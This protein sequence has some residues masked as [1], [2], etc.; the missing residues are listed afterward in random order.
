MSA[1]RTGVV[2]ADGGSRSTT[3]SIG[4]SAC[5]LARSVSSSPVSFTVRT[6]DPKRR[7]RSAST[8]S[9]PARRDDAG[10]ERD[11]DRDG[12]AAEISGRAAHEERLSGLEIG[13]QKAAERHEEDPER[14]PARGLAHVDVA[15][16]DRA[17]ACIGSST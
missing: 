14:T 7:A 4:P 1:A 17:T 2:V 12:G 3:Q 9:F 10:A 8:A 15:E 13:L 6:R 5:I 16:P 11:R